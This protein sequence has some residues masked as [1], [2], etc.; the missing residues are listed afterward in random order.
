MEAQSLTSV[1][2]GTDQLVG[3]ISADAGV[4]LKDCYQCGKCSAGCPVAPMADLMPREVIRN[5]QL[6]NINRV[7][8]SNMPWLCASCGMC[9]ARCPQNVD[10]PNLMLACRRAAQRQGKK[11]LREVATFNSIFIDGV[12]EKGVSDE[13]ALA[14]KFNM[15]SGHLLQD[16]LSA[17]KMVT[18]GMLNLKEHKVEGI[19]EV[20]S[21]IERAR[22]AENSAKSPSA[23][24]EAEGGA[25]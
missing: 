18:R 16:A 2:I 15:S 10:L 1:S 8:E 19:D 7:M 9:Q 17:P 3:E 21:I 22:L 23:P 20:T 5:L 4:D 25:R 24:Q 6:K 14:M 11:P 13:A 12:K